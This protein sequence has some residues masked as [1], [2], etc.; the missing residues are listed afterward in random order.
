MLPCGTGPINAHYGFMKIP[1]DANVWKFK[2]I[3][4]PRAC[5]IQHNLGVA[6]HK[7]LMCSQLRGARPAHLDFSL[8]ECI[9][10]LGYSE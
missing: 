5:C 2:C 3:Q 7:L 10:N 6:L 1:I 9:L 4:C 8:W